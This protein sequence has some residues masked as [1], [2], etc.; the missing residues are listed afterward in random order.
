MDKP[1]FFTIDAS[2]ENDDK[3]PFAHEANFDQD[4][5]ENGTDSDLSILAGEDRLSSTAME[6]FTQDEHSFPN[7]FSCHNTQAVTDKGVPLSRG[8]NQLLDPK[9]INVSHVL[10]QFLLEESQ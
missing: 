2:L 1:G 9:L 10:S 6:S 4:L 3:S 5:R 7:C 8:G